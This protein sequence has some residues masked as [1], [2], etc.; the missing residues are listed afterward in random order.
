MRRRC[1]AMKW[2]A[3]TKWFKR[4]KRQ[5]GVGGIGNKFCISFMILSRTMLEENVRFAMNWL[6]VWL[7]SAWS[8]SNQ[9]SVNLKSN[10]LSAKVHITAW[11]YQYTV[12]CGPQSQVSKR[13]YTGVQT[14]N[15]P[16]SRWSRSW[17]GLLETSQ[18]VSVGMAARQSGYL[19]NLMTGS[20]WRSEREQSA[21]L[22]CR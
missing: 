21:E 17:S 7:C 18:K 9:V 10:Y 8:W 6:N 11:I 13:T 20:R 2:K 15:R 19:Q 3:S 4:S 14:K 12:P 1:G 16:R 5:V 22:T